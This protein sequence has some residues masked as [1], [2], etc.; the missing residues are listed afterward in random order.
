MMAETSREQDR[1]FIRENLD[2]I[3]PDD[4]LQL[5]ADFIA[6]NCHPEAIFDE[7]KLREWAKDNCVP[8][9]IFDDDELGMWAT[10]NGFAEK[11]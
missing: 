5:A 8:E 1:K 4:L 6:D 9:S 7:D 10:A 2:R 3:L 11:E